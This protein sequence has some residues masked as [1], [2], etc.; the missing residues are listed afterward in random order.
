M[1]AFHPKRTFAGTVFS[2]PDVSGVAFRRLAPRA[3]SSIGRLHRHGRDMLRRTARPGSAAEKAAVAEEWVR[4]HVHRMRPEPVRRLLAPLFAFLLPLFAIA[5]CTP[6]P[7]IQ[8]GTELER[9]RSA[10]MRLCAA[11]SSGFTE[12]Q[13]DLFSRELLALLR[14]VRDQGSSLPPLTSV[15][16]SAR[17]ELGTVRSFGPGIFLNAEVRLQGATDRLTLPAQANFRIDNV[18]YGSP[19]NVDG[20]SARDLKTALNIMVLQRRAHASP[21]E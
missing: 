10:V 2:S 4:R 1:S 19:V 18:V 3:Y 5:G 15:D 12:A 21:A 7:K 17:C 6:N 11:A 13:A 16:P 14:Q 9:A 20:R 8:G